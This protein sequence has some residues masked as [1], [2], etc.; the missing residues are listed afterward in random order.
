MHTHLYIADTLTWQ[1]VS[2]TCHK[3]YLP[4]VRR[5]HIAYTWGGISYGMFCIDRCP[6]DEKRKIYRSVRSVALLILLSH[7][8]MFGRMRRSGIFLFDRKFRLL[9]HVEKIAIV[10]LIIARRL[11][12]IKFCCSPIRN[13]FLVRHLLFVF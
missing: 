12:K 8:L 2:N 10:D 4:V 5:S 1:H 3:V 6:L 7:Q 11:N 13:L 9:G